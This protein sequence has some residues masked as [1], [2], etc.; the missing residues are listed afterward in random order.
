MHSVKSMILLLTFTLLCIASEMYVDFG[1]EAGQ[2]QVFESI[3]LARAVTAPGNFWQEDAIQKDIDFFSNVALPNLNII[4][5]I[6]RG[7]CVDVDKSTLNWTMPTLLKAKTA[8]YRKKQ[9]MANPGS[10]AT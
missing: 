9:S 1:A 4:D 6:S 5:S 10:K 2:G 8:I 3:E 7:N